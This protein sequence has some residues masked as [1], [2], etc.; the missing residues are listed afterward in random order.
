MLTSIGLGVDTFAPLS[1]FV[2]PWI[3]DPFGYKKGK[4][5]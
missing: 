2:S 1:W 4:V 5:L 3:V